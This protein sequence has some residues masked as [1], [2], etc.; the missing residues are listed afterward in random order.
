MSPFPTPSVGKALDATLDAIHRL[1]SRREVRHALTPPSGEP[2]T[3]T[4]GWILG[5][6]ADSGPLRMSALA[7]WQNVDRSTMTAQVRRLEERGWV[8]REKDPGDGRAVLVALQPAGREVVS[9]LHRVGQ[10]TLD[11]LVAHWSPQDRQLLVELLGRLVQELAAG[12][13]RQ[14]GTL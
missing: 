9:H 4:D 3:T 14:P 7:G 5:R 2:V 13:E 10:D 8:R 1:R 6:L 12:E 11:R